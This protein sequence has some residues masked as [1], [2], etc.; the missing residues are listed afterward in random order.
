MEPSG[1]SLLATFGPQSQR[2]HAAGQAGDES[3]RRLLGGV[4]LQSVDKLAADFET[5]TT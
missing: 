5:F 1:D 3:V 4:K 2:Q